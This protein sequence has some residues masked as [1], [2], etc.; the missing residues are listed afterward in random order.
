MSVCLRET[1][2]N[3]LEV[4]LWD[5]LLKTSTQSRFWLKSKLTDTLHEFVWVRERV[6]FY[7]NVPRLGPLVL[8]VAV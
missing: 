1:V 6:S 5:F 4:L 3:F 2:P 7:C 8:V